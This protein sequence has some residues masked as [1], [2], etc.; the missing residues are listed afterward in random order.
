MS[1]RAPTDRH[2]A[3][4][5]YGLF[6][7]TITFLLFMIGCTVLCAVIWQGFVVDTLYDCTDSGG[8]PDYFLS[9][10]HWV[11]KPVAVE[12]VVGHRSMS[13]PDTIKTGWSILGLICLRWTFVGASIF[14][15]ILAARLLWGPA[16][17]NSSSDK[18]II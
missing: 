6:G 18:H 8:L 3:F 4:G 11:H 12:H 9:S 10:R 14:S 1:E 2:G 16:Q 17:P 13:E 15:G 5:S 7:R